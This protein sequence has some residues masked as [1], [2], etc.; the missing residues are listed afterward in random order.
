MA[1]D[2][3][4]REEGRWEGGAGH[5][6]E[7]Y[8][9]EIGE[10]GVRAWAGG[11]AGRRWARVTLETLREQS[12]EGWLPEG[13][14]EDWPEFA[15]RGY[16][17]DVSRGRVPRVERLKRTISGLARLKYNRVYL[18]L[19]HPFRFAFDG[20]I[21][22]EDAYG[23]EEIAELGAW[24]AGEGVELR[25]SA[26]TLG[27]MGKVLSLEGF[28]GLAER[29]FGAASWEAASWLQRLRGATLDTGR[30]EGRA[31]L[32]RMLEE[33]LACFPGRRFHLCGDEAY[34]LGAREGLGEEG[35]ARRYA[36]HVRFVAEVA[37]RFGKGIELWGDMCRKHPGAVEGVP[38]GARVGDW[39]YFEENGMDGGRMFR[40]AGLA[41]S[42][43]PSVRGFRCVFP[44]AEAA[45]RVFARQAAAGRGTGA[46]GYL[47]T[48]WGDFGHFGM[49]GCAW[50]GIAAGAQAAWNPAGLG[51]REWDR[52][53]GRVW[54]GS[55][56][57]GEAF[58]RLGA[59][60]ARTTVWPLAAAG[61]VPAGRCGA[62]ETA[63]AAEGEAAAE[64]AREC[65]AAWAAAA[66]GEW[67][68]A[69][70]KAEVALGARFVEFA[71]DWAAG[72]TGG[73]RERWD[74]LEREF[75]RLWEAESLPHGMREMH[76]RGFEPVRAL[77]DGKRGG[78]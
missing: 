67:M 31:L 51:G 12:P 32:E 8:R 76:E 41:V 55:E 66:G 37:G 49:P 11:A 30:A 61:G 10:G 9:L 68:G 20:R 42:V 40:E 56:A 34:D 1:W 15:E 19:E 72:R 44:A 3:R 69:E 23:A 50:H 21:A 77:L 2:G 57:A 18:Y 33:L 64:A 43:C 45:R 5:G 73:L 62:A 78:R 38:A 74:G 28:R 52:G 36:E 22:G 48:D 54:A 24:A 46:D 13:E 14:I 59:A 7:G 75:A 53:W 65:A 58:G 26:A 70:E 4:V 60:D 29:E 47:V 39:A 17:L 6:E 63:G 71:G 27:H 25:G 16:Y 35:K